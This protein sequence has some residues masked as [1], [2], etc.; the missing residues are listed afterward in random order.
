MFKRTLFN[1]RQQDKMLQFSRKSSF[2]QATYNTKQ[3]IRLSFAS[4]MLR[5]L[6][7]DAIFFLPNPGCQLC[8][9]FFFFYLLKV[10][11]RTPSLWIDRDNSACHF[12]VFPL[13][14]QFSVFFGCELPTPPPL[15]L[16]LSVCKC[17]CRCG[18]C[19]RVGVSVRAW[20]CACICVWVRFMTFLGSPLLQSPNGMELWQFYLI[21]DRVKAGIYLKENIPNQFSMAQAS[22]CSETKIKLL[23]WDLW[24]SLDRLSLCEITG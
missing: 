14:F 5:C 23:E 6:Q 2:F 13:P 18:C 11:T 3:T 4:W 21:L 20:A 7:K 17:L 9:R 16:S 10:C 15:S 19:A 24:C 12:W 1:G 8:F 22:V